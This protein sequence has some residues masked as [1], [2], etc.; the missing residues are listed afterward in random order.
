MQP[1][2]IDLIHNLHPKKHMHNSTRFLD[3]NKTNQ[4]P[5]SVLCDRKTPII[6]K[7]QNLFGLSEVQNK[8]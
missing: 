2:Q 7:K 5:I 3:G 6:R 1:P 4:Y 8:I